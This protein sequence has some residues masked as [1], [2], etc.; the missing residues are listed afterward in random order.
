[1]NGSCNNNF[2]NHRLIQTTK[3]NT[4]YKGYLK[5]VYVMYI[6]FLLRHVLL[7]RAKLF[8]HKDFPEEARFFSLREHPSGNKT[9]PF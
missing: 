9:R 5:R 4:R 2:D 3:I 1:M 8:P 7:L 6:R